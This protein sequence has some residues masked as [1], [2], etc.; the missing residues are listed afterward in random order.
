MNKIHDIAAYGALSLTHKQVKDVLAGT[1]VP[2]GTVEV[3]AQRN[4]EWFR[5]EAPASGVQW[6]RLL[7]EDFVRNWP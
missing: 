1:F 4:G 2:Q 7:P 5:A 3:I 6:N